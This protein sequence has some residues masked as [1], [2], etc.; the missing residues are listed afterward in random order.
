ML[1]FSSLLVTQVKMADEFTPLLTKSL[2]NIGFPRARHRAYT[3]RR[4]CSRRCWLSARRSSPTTG[5]KCV[6]IW[7][8]PAPRRLRTPPAPPPTLPRTARFATT[9][10]SSRRY[11][12]STP[13]R[14][15]FP[16]HRPPCH[17]LIDCP[18]RSF[19]GCI[20][21]PSAFPGSPVRPVPA[22]LGCRAYTDPRRGRVAHDPTTHDPTVSPL[23]AL[24]VWLRAT[25]VCGVSTRSAGCRSVHF[26]WRATRLLSDGARALR[27]G[28]G[29]PTPTRRHTQH[30]LALSVRQASSRP[31][32]AL[33]ARRRRGL[34]NFMGCTLIR[35]L[36]SALL[37]GP[38]SASQRSR[39][40]CVFRVFRVFCTSVAGE[41]RVWCYQPLCANTHTSHAA[42]QPR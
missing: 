13:L 4:T 32:G 11:C 18:P 5:T 25:S 24:R 22:R 21:I 1:R 19:R 40:L 29:F 23:R 39:P 10:S 33:F 8:H 12:F 15:L 20:N 3:H 37:A 16:A 30:T 28:G 42:E 36:M 6:I 34:R 38:A 7:T 31:S 35:S 41:L 27:A 9:T 14:P 17:L 2:H 26:G